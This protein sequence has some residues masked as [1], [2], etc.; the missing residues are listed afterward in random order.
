MAYR[1]CVVYGLE[2]H[3]LA[4]ESVPFFVASCIEKTLTNMAN[5]WIAM[6][7]SYRNMTM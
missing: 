6:K 2:H 3:G 1:Q 7:I 5:V 4:L